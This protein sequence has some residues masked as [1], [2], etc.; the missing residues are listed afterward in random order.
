MGERTTE[1]VQKLQVRR[2]RRRT[3]YACEV[4]IVSVCFKDVYSQFDAHPETIG[5]GIIDIRTVFVGK[6][7]G[8]Q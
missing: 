4:H 5:V 8:V 7:G 6:T 1:N 2:R 3:D